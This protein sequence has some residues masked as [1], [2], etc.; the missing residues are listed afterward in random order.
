[1]NN[2]TVRFAALLCLI[3]L[4]SSAAVSPEEKSG[5]RVA[6]KAAIV[7]DAANATV[8][9]TVT[10]HG[11][12]EIVKGGLGIN[13]NRIVL[14]YPSGKVTD[15]NTIV[16]VFPPGR[17]EMMQPGESVT[18]EKPLSSIR[19]AVT[20]AG[21]YRMYWEFSGVRSE[22]LGFT[23]D[24]PRA[25]PK[26][27][28]RV[29]E[30]DQSTPKAALLTLFRATEAGELAGLDALHADKANRAEGDV[31]NAFVARILAM[32]GLKDHA[33]A[34]FGKSAFLDLKIDSDNAT[35]GAIDRATVTCPPHFDEAMVELA[36]RR[37]RVIR[38]RDRW[39]VSAANF[40]SN[41][42][43]DL[44]EFERRTQAIRQTTEEINTRQYRSADEALRVLRKRIDPNPSA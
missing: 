6:V 33:K 34:R 32:T 20:E 31:H 14:L 5:R 41:G 4:G 24:K 11:R 12:D 30:F 21:H 18:W 8:R 43:P 44:A 26:G 39:R 9:F 13:T 3:S 38:D 27:A 10:N 1:M 25:L 2:S 40:L 17:Q 37:Y 36:N 28:P 16:D 19:D 23:Q 15:G 35:V 29:R 7:G 42:K 22:E